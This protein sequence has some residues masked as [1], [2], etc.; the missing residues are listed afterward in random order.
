M[1][2]PARGRG[3]PDLAVG[4]TWSLGATP[5]RPTGATCGRTAPGSGLGTLARRRRTRRR[6][7][8]Y[9][10]E[11]R[12][13]ARRRRRSPGRSWRCGPCT[14][15][16]PTRAI[17]ERDPAAD[18][19]VPRVP[20]GLPKALAEAE[21]DA[22][23]AG[24]GRATTPSPVGTGRSSRCSTAPG[25]AS[26]SS[27]ACPRRDL[28]LE[29]GLLRACRQG[30]PRSG[31]CRSVAWPAARWPTWLAPGGRERAGA[32]SAGPGAATPRRCS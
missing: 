30:V 12:G 24:R 3:V 8:R 9:V 5:S 23:A 16:W 28:D 6:S 1:E 29:G 32:A 14:G 11:L 4:R 19:E 26:P 31:S 25:C 17:V 2:L 27:S 22:A 21:V 15:S 13:R 7:R 10:G 18:V 20:E